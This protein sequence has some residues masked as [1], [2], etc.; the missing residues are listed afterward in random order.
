M[1]KGLYAA[2]S[3]GI[4]VAKDPVAE[5]ERRQLRLFGGGRRVDRVYELQGL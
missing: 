3:R 2:L 5:E 1:F 4:Q